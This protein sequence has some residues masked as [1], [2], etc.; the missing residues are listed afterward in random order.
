MKKLIML[1]I[2]ALSVVMATSQESSQLTAGISD[3]FIE[4]EPSG[5]S[6]EPFADQKLQSVYSAHL[7]EFN[8]EN[9]MT[10]SNVSV[11]TR[12]IRRHETWVEKVEFNFIS[13]QES[14][15]LR[16]GLY[17][18]LWID[19][20][21]PNLDAPTLAYNNLLLYYQPKI[22]RA[23]ENCKEGKMK[24]LHKNWNKSLI[25]LDHH[26]YPEHCTTAIK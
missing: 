8:L 18:D 12:F 9:P 20:M 15:K 24:K 22:D 10:V 3:F 25:R 17:S 2:A 5:S 4:S 21:D 19:L 7:E 1:F 26:F 14:R 16:R 11:M 6:L 13:Q 23:F